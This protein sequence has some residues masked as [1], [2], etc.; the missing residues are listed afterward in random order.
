M[1][2]DR[3]SEWLKSVL[4]PERMEAVKSA[5]DN[6][7]IDNI[8][9]VAQHKID[10]YLSYLGIHKGDIVQHLNN[11]MPDVWTET[12]GKAFAEFLKGMGG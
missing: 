5:M 10:L 11:P 4:T 12:V 8:S 6:F 3:I 9:R 1:N 7:F 2:E